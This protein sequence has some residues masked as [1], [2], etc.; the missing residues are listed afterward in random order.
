MSDAI[1]RSRQ[2]TPEI[3]EEMSKR[4]GIR[5][6]ASMIYELTRNGNPVP[7]LRL[8][9]TWVPAFCEV[10]GDDRLRR[11]LAGPRL[12][13]LIETGE[14]VHSLPQIVGAIQ[15]SVAKLMLQERGKKPE[16]KRPRKA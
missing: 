9:A 5:V 2:T 11:W 4:L 7:E 1:T 16:R 13:E 8:L 6:T 3:A 14:R 12:R 15:A 10:T